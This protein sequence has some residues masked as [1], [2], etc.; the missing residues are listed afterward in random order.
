[1]NWT[2]F[3]WH[4]SELDYLVVLSNDYREGLYNISVLCDCVNISW[5]GLA[6]GLL[7]GP[8]CAECDNV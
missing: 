7:D 8:N 4:N 5:F 1:M 3:C 6:V 2:L